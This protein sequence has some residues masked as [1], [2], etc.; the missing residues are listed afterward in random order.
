MPQ[1][2]HHRTALGG[3]PFWACRLERASEVRGLGITIVVALG[4]AIGIATFGHVARLCVND[5]AGAAETTT[6]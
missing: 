6:Q 3:S 4:I 1:R 5:P 2:T